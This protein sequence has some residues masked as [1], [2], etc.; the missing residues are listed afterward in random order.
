MLHNLGHA[1]SLLDVREVAN[2]VVGQQTTI[3]SFFKKPG[4]K[5]TTKKMQK[6]KL[7]T[8][9]KPVSTQTTLKIPSKTDKW[10]CS[11]CTF[12][13]SA[14]LQSCAMCGSRKK[15][16]PLPDNNNSSNSNNDRLSLHPSIT[17]TIR[18]KWNCATCTFQNSNE[19]KKC[20][21]CGT[22]Q[23]DQ[24]RDT[25]IDE[26]DTTP[27]T[28]PQNWSCERCTFLNTAIAKAC[29]MCSAIN[30]NL[31]SPKASQG[32]LEKHRAH[33]VASG[34]TQQGTLRL[35]RIRN[36]WGQDHS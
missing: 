5:S 20:R 21:M 8:S 28:V 12:H 17:P 25:K 29:S 24:K 18:T 34:L 11:A 23:P 19:T 32:V 36:P 3:T 30:P 27:T 6:R 35:L 22:A 16:Q 13:N 9:A 14:R 10:V 1:Y 26:M 31:P 2:A 7:T 4:L 15:A 33:A